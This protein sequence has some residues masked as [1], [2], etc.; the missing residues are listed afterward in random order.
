MRSQPTPGPGSESPAFS[1]PARLTQL[2]ADG[3]VIDDLHALDARVMTMVS[4][5]S[6]ERA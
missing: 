2:F 4:D 3:S 1:D 6:R 5:N